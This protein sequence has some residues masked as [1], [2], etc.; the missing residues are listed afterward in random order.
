MRDSRA[1]QGIACV[2]TLGAAAAF[3]LTLRGGLPPRLGSKPHE[4]AGWYMAQQTLRCLQPGGQ[5]ILIARDTTLFQNPATDVQLAS[6]RETL[7]KS[8]VTISSVQLLG[9]DPL[10]PME[11]PAGDFQELI[12]KAPKGSV[13]ASF[14]GPPP[15]LNPAQR[16]RLEETKPT[17]VAFCPGTLPDRVNLPALFEQ[18][19]L[20]AAVIS[21]RDPASS[22]AAAKGLQGWFD[23]VFV[24]VT[25]AEAASLSTSSDTPLPA[26]TP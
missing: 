9:V 26:R 15:L 2:I 16:Q 14:M 24:G 13:I 11:V 22:A 12:R 20:Q 7:R 17:V 19:L 4:A 21:R 3:C 10:R 25:G 8:H 1:I 5:V 23:Q 6:F 18:G